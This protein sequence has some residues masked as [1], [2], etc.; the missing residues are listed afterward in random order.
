MHSWRASGKET[1][2][3]PELRHLEGVKG[4]FAVSDER[5]YVAT[6]QLQMEK[7]VTQL[8]YSN[9]KAAIEQQQYMSFGI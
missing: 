4:G 8:I 2:A 3:I 9:V 1:M 6:A 7:L 5:V